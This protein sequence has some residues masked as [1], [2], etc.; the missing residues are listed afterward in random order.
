MTFRAMNHHLSYGVINL[1]KP[2]NPSSH[3]VVS[4]VKKILRVEK[5][6]HSGTLDPKVTGCLI[7]CIDPANL[8]LLNDF[9]ADRSVTRILEIEC[10]FSDDYL[11]GHA[12][13]VGLAGDQTSQDTLTRLLPTIRNDMIHETDCI[14]DA[15]FENHCRMREAAEPDDNADALAA[16]L[17]ISAEKAQEIAR[18]EYLFAD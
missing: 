17:N 18:T 11:I 9:A 13:R 14:R 4:W 8:D 7:V 2:A 5:T 16:F 3:E 15:Q 6:G 1:D 12:M 10:Q